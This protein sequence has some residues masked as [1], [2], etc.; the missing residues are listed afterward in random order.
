MMRRF[1]VHNHLPWLL[2][3][4]STSGCRRLWVRF[5]AAHFHRC[6]IWYKQLPCV[7]LGINMLAPLCGT[8][9]P[10]AGGCGFDFQPRLFTGVEF[11]TNNSLL[12]C[13]GVLFGQSCFAVYDRYPKS[14]TLNLCKYVQGK[15]STAHFCK[16][17]QVFAST[18]LRNNVHFH[19]SSFI[20]V[21]LCLCFK[22]DT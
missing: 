20:H 5:P 17:F 4:A 18:C 8:L 11:G 22:V 19:A 16:S 1:V 15:M 9:P 14:E 6:E 2:V 3:R 10:V 21:Y 12:H 7:A 13:Y